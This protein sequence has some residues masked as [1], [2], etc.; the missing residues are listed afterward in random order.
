MTR[1]FNDRVSYVRK[2]KS[3][4]LRP[5]DPSFLWYDPSM[6]LRSNYLF[7]PIRIIIRFF[8]LFPFLPISCNLSKCMRENERRESFESTRY[9]LASRRIARNRLISF[10]NG[11]EKLARSY[12]YPSQVFPRGCTVG[13]E[14]SC[15]I[16]R[17]RKCADRRKKKPW[18]ANARAKKCWWMIRRRTRDRIELLDRFF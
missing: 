9:G 17:S 18:I 3:V 8:F 6:S 10:A 11:D 7:F 2:T 15:F 1:L 4:S 13:R 14:E 5:S 12:S 16:G